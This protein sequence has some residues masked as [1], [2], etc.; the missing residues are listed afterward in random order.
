MTN[1]ELHEMQENSKKLGKSIQ[2]LKNTQKKLNSQFSSSQIKEILK[3]EDL[4]MLK[5][6]LD[7]DLPKDIFG[8]LNLFVSKEKAFRFYLL[9]A[10]R[11]QKNVILFD[12]YDENNIKR[13][14][15][16]VN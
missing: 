2:K 3:H 11:Y 15:W 1:Q 4:E 16:K 7:K 14:E 5:K 6:V 12:E 9:L 8:Y 13:A 10:D